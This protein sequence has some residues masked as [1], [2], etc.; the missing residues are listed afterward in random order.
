MHFRLDTNSEKLREAIDLLVPN[1]SEASYELSRKGHC[2]QLVLSVM[3]QVGTERPG[4]CHSV[5]LLQTHSCP[6]RE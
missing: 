5:L 6:L 1:C 3:G 2:D 4:Y